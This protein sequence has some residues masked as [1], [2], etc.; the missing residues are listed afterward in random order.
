MV[1]ASQKYS[2]AEE[3]VGRCKPDYER[4][5]T[6]QRTELSTFK[7]AL[8]HIKKLSSHFRVVGPVSMMELIGYLVMS[9]EQT[10]ER[11][12]ILIDQQEEDK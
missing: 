6:Q 1:L 8:P 2:G 5:I 9:I 7:E 12:A 11:I 3:A 10:E 4:L